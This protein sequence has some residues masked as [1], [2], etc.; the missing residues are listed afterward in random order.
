MCGSATLAMVVSSTC[1]STAIITAM[2]TMVRR[3]GSSGWLAT[4]G[5]GFRHAT[6]GRR[7][8]PKR[9]PRGRR[10]SAATGLPSIAIRT[11]TRCVTLTQLPLAFC[12]GITANS[13]PVPAPMLCDVALQARGRDKRRS[14]MSTCCPGTISREVLLLEIGLD[15]RAL[16]VDQ[17][18]QPD[19][20]RPPPARPGAGRRWRRCRP[21]APARRCASGRAGPCRPRPAPAR[22]KAARPARLP[23]C[24]LAERARAS[25]S[26]GFRR[27]ALR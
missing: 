22:P 25:A 13:L 16:V 14:S 24:A 26:C 23:H 20:R 7:D 21:S 4:P 11:G 15:P 1:S 12:A 9:S 2:V 5:A 3:C 18:K 17:R 8:G 27:R 6:S 10:P 19:A